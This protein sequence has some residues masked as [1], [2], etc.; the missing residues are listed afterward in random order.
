MKKIDSYYQTPQW[1]KLLLGITILAGLPVLG[2]FV[3]SW[4][5]LIMMFSLE[6]LA[7]GY[8]AESYYEKYQM[9]LDKLKKLENKQKVDG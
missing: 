5:G 1:R 7:L 4:F 6:V 9:C 2:Y 8:F 3:D